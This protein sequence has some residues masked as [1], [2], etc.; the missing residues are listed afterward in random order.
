MKTSRDLFAVIDFK[1]QS[2]NFLDQYDPYIIQMIS[3]DVQPKIA[4][5]NLGICEKDFRT[6]HPQHVVN[7]LR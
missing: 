7:R 4:C 6:A 5:Q 1:Q 2:E 3:S